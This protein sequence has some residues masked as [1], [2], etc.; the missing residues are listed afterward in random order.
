MLEYTTSLLIPR[1][2]SASPMLL[3]ARW[4]EHAL[5]VPIDRPHDADAREHRRAAERRHQDQSFHGCLPFR[6]LVNGVRKL[7]DVIAGRLAP[8]AHRGKADLIPKRQNV[9]VWPH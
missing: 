1:E 2:L 6:S 5:D 3:F 9:Q 7:G 4:A 8:S